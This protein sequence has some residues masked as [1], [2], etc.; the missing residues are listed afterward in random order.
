MKLRMK[1]PKAKIKLEWSGTCWY[2]CE[3]HGWKFWKFS[4]IL[5]VGTTREQAIAEATEKLRLQR[6]ERGKRYE[7]D[8]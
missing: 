5:G 8:L 6:S 7:V 4:E 3:D 2:A 1:P